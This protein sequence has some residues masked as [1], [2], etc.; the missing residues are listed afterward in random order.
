M[1]GKVTYQSIELYWDEPALESSNGDVNANGSVER[2][3]YCVQEDDS[4]R[5]LHPKGF[6]TVYTLVMLR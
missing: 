2:M 5:T 6:G 1:V 3:R 4:S